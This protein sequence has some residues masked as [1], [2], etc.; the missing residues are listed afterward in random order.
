MRT[1]VASLLTG[2]SI[3]VL[4]SVKEGLPYTIIEA[5][6]AE[7]PVVAT[8]VGGIPEL[9]EHKKNGLLVEP[10]NVESLAGAIELLL[11]DHALSKQFTLA[12]HSK[13]SIEFNLEQMVDKTITIYQQ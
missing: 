9:I 3:F 7:V 10:R 13:V 6:A 2:F 4:P 11:H 5:M 8:R 12:S 1:N